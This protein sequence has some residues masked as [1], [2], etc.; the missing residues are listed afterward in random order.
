MSALS[1]T[2]EN[3]ASS[4][5]G[6]LN[7]GSLFALNILQMLKL[8]FVR[9]RT[10]LLVFVLLPTWLDAEETS[11]QTNAPNAR[12][13]V[14]Q[15]WLQPWKPQRGFNK[16]RDVITLIDFNG[17]L[18]MLGRKKNTWIKSLISSHRL[19]DIIL[20]L[21]K[22]NFL[23]WQQ[24]LCNLDLISCRKNTVICCFCIE[25]EGRHLKLGWVCV[26]SGLVLAGDS[27]RVTQQLT[28]PLLIPL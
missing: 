25:W 13:H 22:T 2:A 19:W 18:S 27:Y 4:L 23:T 1:V 14:Q 21:T 24:I 6:V 11:N 16:G 12:Q 15:L 9:Q 7:G 5:E 3:T 10:G 26:V 8:S 17:V 28:H 20:G